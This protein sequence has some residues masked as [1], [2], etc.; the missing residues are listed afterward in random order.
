MKYIFT[1]IIAAIPCFAVSNVTWDKTEAG[2]K[3][4]TSLLYRRYQQDIESFA[5]EMCEAPLHP[6]YQTVL[7]VQ[8]SGMANRIEKWTVSYLLNTAGHWGWATDKTASAC[9]TSVYYEI[10]LTQFLTQPKTDITDQS[11]RFLSAVVKPE[12]DRLLS[13]DRFICDGSINWANYSRFRFTYQKSKRW[14]QQ[15][16][17]NVGTLLG[18]YALSLIASVQQELPDQG[19]V[20]FYKRAQ[21]YQVLTQSQ[22]SSMPSQLKEFLNLLAADSSINFTLQYVDDIK[23]D[24]LIKY[25]GMFPQDSRPTGALDTPKLEEFSVVI[26]GGHTIKRT[27]E[28]IAIGF[29]RGK[30]IALGA[31]ININGLQPVRDLIVRHEFTP[32]QFVDAIRSAG[33]TITDIMPP[34]LKHLLAQ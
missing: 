10:A 19:E 5:T 17:P 6:F 33:L 9:E 8:Q 11:P 27:K 1:L 16:I 29:T 31:G 30:N 23:E 25:R 4:Y 3:D 22:L 34:S 32:K 2:K 24:I 28:S 18:Y 7:W 15:G 14:S 13:E 21:A 26:V 12:A 20:G